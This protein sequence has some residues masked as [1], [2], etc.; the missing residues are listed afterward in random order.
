MH[1][2]HG[3]TDG[4][5]VAVFV[6]DGVLVTGDLFFHRLYP[7]IDLEAGG[8]ISAW[9]ATLDEVMTLS[10]D[11]VTPGHG[12]VTDRAGLLAFRTFMAERAD[13]AAEARARGW[14]HEET[15]TQTKFTADTGY[16]EITM[17]IPIG[18]NREFLMGRAGDEA[19]ETFEA[20]NR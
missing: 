19:T 17:R 1:P 20:Y 4:D 11:H 7:N 15:I 8:S 5:L 12:A 6:E 18:L 10:F 13:V 14:S 9:P 16:E 3:H 2:G